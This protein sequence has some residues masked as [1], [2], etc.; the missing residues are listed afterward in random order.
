MERVC[1]PY[2]DYVRV[3]TPVMILEFALPGLWLAALAVSA[4]GLLVKMIR[5]LVRVCLHR[6]KNTVMGKWSTAACVSQ[7]VTLILFAA[8]ASMVSGYAAGASYGWIFAVLGLL[9]VWMSGMV[10]YGIVGMRKPSTRIR[11][12]YHAVTIF[13]LLTTVLN[14]C[15][16][17]LYRFW[18]L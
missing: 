6:D 9:A 2:S 5:Y 13:F 11:K 10:I 15:Y 3:P 17:N 1:L 7:L 4:M 12:L 14:I 18:M 16:W 8:A